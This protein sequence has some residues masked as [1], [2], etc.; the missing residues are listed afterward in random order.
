MQVTSISPRSFINRNTLTH[1]D[2]ARVFL[3]S[4]EEPGLN[5][6]GAELPPT[7]VA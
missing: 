7:P 1:I 4:T 3:F 2:W 6:A 5:V